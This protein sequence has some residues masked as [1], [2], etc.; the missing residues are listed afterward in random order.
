MR[1]LAGK[2]ARD[3]PVTRHARPLSFFVPGR[4]GLRGFV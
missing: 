2:G 4:G 1:L 3:E